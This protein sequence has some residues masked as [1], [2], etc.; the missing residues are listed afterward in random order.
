LRK[1]IRHEQ[2][3]TTFIEDSTPAGT[4][5][6]PGA[7]VS[8]HHRELPLCLLARSSCLHFQDPGEKALKLQL[9]S[10]VEYPASSRQ[11]WHSPATHLHLFAVSYFEDY[12][13]LQKF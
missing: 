10:L 9:L 6:L 12:G 11:H 8:L 3:Q 5:D 1:H 2:L 7:I 13:S 4:L